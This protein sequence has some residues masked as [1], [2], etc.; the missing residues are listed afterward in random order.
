MVATKV[1]KY[2]IKST[3]KA[4]LKRNGSFVKLIQFARKCFKIHYKKKD[5]DKIKELDSLT[6][7][8]VI[9]LHSGHNL[10]SSL[11]L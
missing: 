2:Y 4:K 7:D 3:N 8:L 11:K 1:L 9:P 5:I 6:K 10:V